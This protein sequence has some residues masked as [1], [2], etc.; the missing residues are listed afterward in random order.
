MSSGTPYGYD[1]DEIDAPKFMSRGEWNLTGTKS[2][3]A[4]MPLKPNTTLSSGLYGVSGLFEVYQW[5][6]PYDDISGLSGCIGVNIRKLSKATDTGLRNQNIGLRK[7]AVLH[8]G[9]CIMEYMSGTLDGTVITLKY[10]DAIAPTWSGFRAYEEINY[11]T[12]YA[13]SAAPTVETG[14]KVPA[15]TGVF[16]SGISPTSAYN[17]LNTGIRQVKL[18]WF[19]D[20]VSNKTGARHR[21]K[22]CP[23]SIYGTTK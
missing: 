2:C 4:W 15:G 7:M 20:V 23:N 13:F 5:A 19:A 10:G 18:G 1:I 12:I 11:D 3:D 22:I 14:A 9:Y 6:E 16:I 21:V 17:V 8:E